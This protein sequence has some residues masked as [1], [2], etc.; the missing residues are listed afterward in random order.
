MS[1]QRVAK[2]RVLQAVTVLV[3]ALHPLCAFAA[4]DIT[5]RPLD[6]GEESRTLSKNDRLLPVGNDKLLPIL[7]SPEASKKDDQP[8]GG[9][10]VLERM[11]AGLPDLPP[12]KAYSGKLDDAYGA[13]QRGFYL[14]AMNLALPK[15][16]VG[17]AAAQT[18]VAELLNNG[19]G[20]RR[21]QQDA[22]FWYEQAA[23]A[24]DANAQFKYALM[25]LE[26]RLVAKDRKLADQMMQMSADGGNR[27]AQF[28][29]AQIKVAAAPGE[30]G[31]M[32]ALPYYEKAAEQG[33]PDAQYALAQ[34]Y[35]NLPVSREKQAQARFWLQKAA[36]ARFDTALY[37]MGVWYING[38]GGDK[39]Y[40]Q[41]FAWLKRAANRGHVVAQNKLAYLYINAIGTRPDPIE[42]AKWY[43]LSRRAG[44]ADLG[45]EDFFLGIE[46][47]KQKE[48]IHRAN[49][50]RAR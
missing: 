25:L 20:V 9:L 6:A 16:Q 46:E 18:L 35:V 2:N 44:L 1:G 43:V 15:A 41:G 21:N 26:G 14:T 36:N 4:E 24:G 37:D 29:I 10:N 50:F 34:L 40:E 45:L 39:D 22:A 42:A 32:D 23:K 28:N 19:L 11:G 49:L 5:T 33:V 17:Q 48:A 31:L 47:A 38:I 30:K 27:E 12:E 8:S 3:A 13:Y 7:T